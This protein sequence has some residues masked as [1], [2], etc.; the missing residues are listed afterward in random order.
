MIHFLR[1][2]N[3]EPQFL[4]M[5]ITQEYK[6]K[7]KKAYWKGE[8]WGGSAQALTGKKEKDKSEWILP[9]S[10]CFSRTQSRWER[11]IGVIHG[12]GNSMIRGF[13]LIKV[14]PT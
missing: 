9:N 12:T 2:E 1:R 8:A 4:Y 7:K 11:H 14:F 6:R 3:C 5:N 13:N 10:R